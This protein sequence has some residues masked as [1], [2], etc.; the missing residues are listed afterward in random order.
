MA[1]NRELIVSEL[2]CYVQSKMSSIAH[3]I[4]IK[5]IISFY[6]DDEISNGKKMLFDKADETKTR[7]KTYRTDKARLDIQDI[8]NKFNELGDKCPIFVA[9]NLSNVPLTTI[10]SVELAKMSKDLADV[11]NLKTNVVASFATLSCLQTDFSTLIDKMGKIDEIVSEI[12][13]LKLLLSSKD[14]HCVKKPKDDVINEDEAKSDLSDDDD[15]TED[16]ASNCDGDIDSDGSVII[17]TTNHA[18]APKPVAHRHA[19]PKH[20]TTRPAKP[21]AVIDK[22]WITK[23]G[24]HLVTQKTN[25]HKYSDAVRRD[26]NRIYVNSSRKKAQMNITLK[27]VKPVSRQHRNE[28]YNSS[29]FVSRLDPTTK[30]RDIVNYLQIHHNRQFKVEQIRSKYDNYSSFKIVVPRQFGSALL[31]KG[32]WPNDAYVRPWIEKPRDY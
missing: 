22:D 12:A 32:N 18:A 14:E 20:V 25:K 28:Q 11:L 29:V 3:D 7:Y 30:S 4:I 5:A 1:T 15:D 16:G 31:N 23:D 6:G 8:I 24:F 2:L 19:A 13:L 9:E 10:D 27:T 26:S 17:P 21:H